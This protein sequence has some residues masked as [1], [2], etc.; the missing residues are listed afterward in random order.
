VKVTRGELKKII[1]E[2]IEKALTEAP[3]DKPFAGPAPPSG[4]C[5][6]YKCNDELSAAAGNNHGD[7]KMG[8]LYKMVLSAAGKSAPEGENPRHSGKLTFDQLKSDAGSA[9]ITTQ[10]VYLYGQILRLQG[11]PVP[12]KS[13]MVA[14]ALK[15]A[16]GSS[17][18]KK[19]MLYLYSILSG[20]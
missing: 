17:K 5:A 2:E 13:S 3:G 7:L 1:K 15:Q 9:K 12:E 14:Q 8:H 4:P 19:Q 20:D 11:Q 16:A 18:F 6:P 10:L